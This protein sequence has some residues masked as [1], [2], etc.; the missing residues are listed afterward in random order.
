MKMSSTIACALALGVAPAGFAQTTASDQ[1]DRPASGQTDHYQAGQPYEANKAVADDQY[2]ADR[3]V[4]QGLVRASEL[5]EHAVYNNQDEQVGTIYDVVLDTQSGQIKYA[6]VSTGGFLGL[7][8]SLHAVPWKALKCE[9]RDGE[10]VC[11]LDIDRET[12]EDAKGFDQ[13]NWPN[14]AN[15]QWRDQND[16][17]YQSQN[18]TTTRS[19]SGQQR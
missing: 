2:G 4:P 12:L 18:S 8:D 19:T 7:G 10:Q 14:M 11:V 15:R 17:Q 13:D 16:R 9:M 6:A 5:M 1:A 3:T